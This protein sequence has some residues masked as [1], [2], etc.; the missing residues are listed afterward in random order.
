M[1]KQWEDMSPDEK[2][3]ALFQKWMSPEGAEFKSP[4]AEKLY[5]ER[6]TRIKDAVQ[7]KKK[8][9]RVPVF[10]IPSFAPAY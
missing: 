7:L 5:K 1:E 9:D 4:E 10:L 3:E 2:Q 6:A 8:P